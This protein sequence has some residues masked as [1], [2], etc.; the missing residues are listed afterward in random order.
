MEMSKLID[1]QIDYQ[2]L[3]DIVAKKLI[4]LLS[5]FQNPTLIW[6]IINYLTKLLEKSIDSNGELG[7]IFDTIN[8]ENLLKI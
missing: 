4:P 6:N 1:K 8:I 2:Q 3:L 7:S 5:K